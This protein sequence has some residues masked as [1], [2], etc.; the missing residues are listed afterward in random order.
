MGEKPLV[1]LGACG[2]F[3]VLEFDSRTATRVCRSS[4]AA[5]TRGLGLHMDSLQF[6]EVLLSEMLGESAPS[7]ESLH[8]KQNSIEWPKMTVTDARD[9]YDKLLTEKSGLPQQ[10]ALTLE[11]ATNLRVAGQLRRSDTLD[12]RRK[13]DHERTDE[14]Q[15]GVKTTPGPNIARRREERTRKRYDFWGG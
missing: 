14:G 6:Y 10:K 4:M 13:H 15:Q 2:K 9:V 5:E 12:R 7:S 11:N 8:L 1:S 3:N